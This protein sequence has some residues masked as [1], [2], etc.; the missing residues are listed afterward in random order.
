VWVLD[1]AL[2]AL[3][4]V[5]GA[6]ELLL[7]GDMT[8]AELALLA[9]AVVPVAF[10]RIAPVRAA[11]AVA[12]ANLVTWNVDP[13]VDTLSHLAAL[14]AV[15]VALGEASSVLGG[16]GFVGVLWVALALEPHAHAPLVGNLAFIAV[17]VAM[18]WAAGRAVSAQRAR[19]AELHA[20]TRRLTR[21]RETG[22]RLAVVEERARLAG[23][24]HDA[25]G[26]AVAAML[27]QANAARDLLLRDPERARRALR[28]VQD[29]GR[30]AIDQL[31]LTL[32][33][34][35]SD[36]PVPAP[37]APEPELD[38][39]PSP[40]R[41]W[42]AAA[43]W[44]LV[45]GLA[46]LWAVEIIWFPY[47]DDGSQAIG[48]ALA[49]PAIAAVAVRRRAPVAAAL[50]VVTAALG[51]YLLGGAWDDGLSIVVAVLIAAYALGMHPVRRRAI[52]GG[53]VFLLAMIAEEVITAAGNA[54]DVPAILLLVA[55]PW[56]AGWL[57][58]RDR[59]RAQALGE[60]A[61][62]LE[63]ERRANARLA[64]LAERTHMA[65]ELH[66]TVA[67]GVSVMVVQAAAAE[68]ASHRDPAMARAAV[69]AV[70]GA[71]RDALVDLQRLLGLL[72]VG[73]GAAP[74]APQPT[75]DELDAVVA[76]VRRA[77]LPVTLRVEGTPAPVPP[78]VAGTA[79]RIVQEALT[80][81]LKHAGNPPTAVVV[82][83]T[84]DALDL[85]VDDEGPGPPAVTNGGHGVIGML[86]RARL[87]GGELQAGPRATGGYGVHARLPLEGGAR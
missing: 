41:R 72:D 63:R 27:T 57:V 79:Y 87:A 20:L 86:E 80:N 1:A 61:L 71:G 70:A 3:L 84:G 66:D 16:L 9:A 24:V 69:E 64:V 81:V 21:E 23:E 51:D 38:L 58:R 26:H 75:L 19:R 22:A 46:T 78:D 25:V 47:P 60:M 2:A 55:V 52:A 4:L 17:I 59:D 74:R 42:P 49:V 77:G 28:A 6:L 36:Q 13:P 65:R 50:V 48:A 34:L 83:Y 33:V 30:A 76:Q 85:A 68:Q 40:R 44:G 31:R 62:E 39:R 53:L 11:L 56:A 8:A 37:D 32:R 43:E 67:H 10:R 15:A 73:N 35:R 12:L 82:R 54:G 45:G 7:R 18:A 5:L 14:I 29:S